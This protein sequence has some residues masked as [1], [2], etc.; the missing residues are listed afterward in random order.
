[1]SRSDYSDDVDYQW[2][3]ICWRGAVAKAISGKRGQAFL[4]EMLQALDAMPEHRLI[5]GALIDKGNVCAIGAVGKSRSVEM[6]GLDPEDVYTIAET[7]G[8]SQAL[9]REI[10]FMNDE[11]AVYNETPEQR[12]QRMRRWV[13]SLIRTAAEAVTQESGTGLKA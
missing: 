13:S 4:K 11:G 10:Y 6:S 2:A 5:D 8:V 1:M 7:F 3:Y 9:V 12:Y